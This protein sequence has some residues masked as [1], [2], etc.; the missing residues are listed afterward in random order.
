M[1]IRFHSMEESAWENGAE[2]NKFFSVLPEES[3]L[4]GIPRAVCFGLD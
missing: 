2:V 1:N 3:R 4:S